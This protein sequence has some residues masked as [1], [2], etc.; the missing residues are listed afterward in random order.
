MSNA[1]TGSS[2]N[3]SLSRGG[4]AAPQEPR[5]R[6]STAAGVTMMRI[7]RIP[8]TLAPPSV[9]ALVRGAAAVM[10]PASY[11]GR[12]VREL[13]AIFPSTHPVPFASGR[14]ALATALMLSM[15]ATGRRVVVLPAYTSFSVA[16]AAAAA[17]ARVRL[18]DL[19][20][21]T[22]D[23][24]RRDLRGC[25]DDQ[26]AAVVL[27]NLFGYPSAVWDLDW[28][29]DAGALLIDDAAQALGGVDR[30]A[31]VGGRGD[32]GVVSLGRGKC[33]TTGDGGALL[34]HTKDLR[35]YLADQ[36]PRARVLGFKEWVVACAVQASASPGLFGLMSR[37]SG[38]RI[39]ES[40]YEPEF[41]IRSAGASTNGLAHGLAARV[42]QERDCRAAAAAGWALALEPCGL[43][44][45]VQPRDGAEPAYLR[46]P[47]VATDPTVRDRISTKLHDVGFP[48]VRSYP[49]TL[50]GIEEFRRGWCED[51][52][53][54]RAEFLAERLLALPCHRAVSVAHIERAAAALTNPVSPSAEPPG[55]AKTLVSS[56]V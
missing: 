54:P 41:A 49:T 19:D 1:D 42:S 9:G 35:S 33:V 40:V 51:R 17:G 37:L 55:L 4:F 43:I 39:G 50:G 28:V 10:R 23:F 31:P 14:A 52:R 36:R 5:A 6:N 16:A 18:C 44:E 38:T 13:K 29:R 12:L 26:T 2:D 53:T 32:L 11:R 46:Y 45:H 48:Y 21:V 20:P 7:A 15:R 25:V 34:V 22:L 30:G 8:P 47:V 56:K 27:G 3:D 24:D